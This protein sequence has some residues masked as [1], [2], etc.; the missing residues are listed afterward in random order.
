MKLHA[1]LFD[2]RKYNCTIPVTI[3][4]VTSYILNPFKNKGIFSS[5]NFDHVP[6]PVI[7]KYEPEKLLTEIKKY[8]NIRLSIINNFP[9]NV[10]SNYFDA[11]FAQYM[12]LSGSYEYDFQFFNDISRNSILTDECLKMVQMHPENYILAYT[13]VCK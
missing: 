1:V 6:E 11:D 10:K 9:E 13:M 3:K 8:R 5:N 4:A 12:Q 2:N 7:G